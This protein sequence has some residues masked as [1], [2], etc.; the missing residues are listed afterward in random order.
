MVTC[1][2]PATSEPGAARYSGGPDEQP[3]SAS[4]AAAV[5]SR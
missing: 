4:V 1:A 5:A 3:A 2:V